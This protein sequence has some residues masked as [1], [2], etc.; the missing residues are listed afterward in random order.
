MIFLAINVF[1]PKFHTDEILE[2]IRL[3]LDKGWTGVG[4]K[5]VEFEEKWKEYS[6][7]K[8]AHFLNSNT[9]GLHLAVRVLKLKFGWKDGDEIITT[10]FTFISPNHAILY[11]NLKPVFADVD[12]YLCLDPKSVEKRITPKTRAVMFVGV[13]GNTGQ[14]EEIIR[15]CKKHN[16]KLILDAAHMAGTKFNEKHIGPEADVVVFSYHAVKN[17]PSADSGMIC[18]A[19]SSLD[20]EVRK[21][22]W[23]G[24]NKD[25][26]QRF[27]ETQSSYKWRY[28]VD[29]IGFKYHGNSVIAAIA[30]VQLKYLEEDNA[31]RV[32]IAMLYDKLLSG[33]NGV[34]VVKVAP[35]CKSS[36]HLYQIC[37]K[38][39][40][41]IV[42][43]F[44]ENEIY[45]GVHYIDNTD[46]PMY[47][48]GKGTCPV[49]HKKSAEVITLP[50]HL[51]LT[52]DD[53]KRIVD[54]LKSGLKKFE[55]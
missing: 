24:I 18:F 22:S 55:N 6:G 4:F 20:K 28:A 3:C 42:Q 54:V 38:N 32:E 50:I 31:R 7:V 25:T 11:E 5:T 43:H 27:N 1:V 39:R 35:N 13:G 49:A 23:L 46:Y 2:E 34:E 21:Q 16:L 40:D 36:R 47:S 51:N 9:S 12:E 30:I 8:N 14:Y 15:I 52:D 53:C 44:Y 33:V 48:Y 19:D 37:V 45:P 10:P 41:D 29:E 17:L 26:Y